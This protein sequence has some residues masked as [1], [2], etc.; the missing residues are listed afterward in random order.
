MSLDQ[1]HR[2]V[3]SFPILT[4]SVIN[5]A[6]DLPISWYWAPLPIGPSRMNKNLKNQPH[7]NKIDFLILIFLFWLQQAKVH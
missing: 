4:S 7:H 6:I 3:N 1:I 2:T 5:V